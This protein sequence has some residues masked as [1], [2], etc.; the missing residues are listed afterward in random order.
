MEIFATII[1]ILC[2]V[3]LIWF[4]IYSNLLKRD[5]QDLIDNVEYYKRVADNKRMEY[6]DLDEEY[7]I[8]RKS[9][10]A[11][12]TWNTRYRNTIEW[13]KKEIEVKE[14]IRK[15]MI[16]ELALLQDYNINQGKI[17]DESKVV[18]EFLVTKAKKSEMEAAKATAKEY[19][20][21]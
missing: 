18:V 21:M 9:N 13:L 10:S 11:N 20:R 14:V 8:I 19:Y 3:F 15:K 7:N 4:I 16:K 5:N 1:Q 17:I 6:N 12:Q 2:A